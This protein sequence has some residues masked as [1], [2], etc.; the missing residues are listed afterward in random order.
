ML[1][2]PLFDHCKSSNTCSTES[3]LRLRVNSHWLLRSWP[4]FVLMSI[5]SSLSCFSQSKILSLHLTLPKRSHVR[6]E[7]HV[8]SMLIHSEICPHVERTSLASRFICLEH[9]RS[10]VRKWPQLWLWLRAFCAD[11]NMASKSGM[12]TGR[13]QSRLSFG[14]RH[15]TVIMLPILKS[16]W[17]RCIVGVSPSTPPWS[18]PMGIATSACQRTLTSLLPLQCG[19]TWVRLSKSA[20][21]C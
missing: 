18:T 20:D 10:L 4:R 21:M 17:A 19:L 3:C 11:T 1:F 13:W 7:A 15:T 2:I 6:G 14:R 16:V 9:A 5:L 12:R 8:P